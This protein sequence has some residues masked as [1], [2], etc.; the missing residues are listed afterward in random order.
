MKSFLPCGTNGVLV[1]S[2]AYVCS[3]LSFCNSVA[4]NGRLLLFCYIHW[5]RSLKTKSLRFCLDCPYFT[6]ATLLPVCLFYKRSIYYLF[7]L[8]VYLYFKPY[9]SIHLFFQNK[10]HIEKPSITHTLVS[11]TDG[12]C[13]D[14]MNADTT[15]LKTIL[16]RCF[17][18]YVK[19]YYMYTCAATLSLLLIIQPPLHTLYIYNKFKSSCASELCEN[20][21]KRS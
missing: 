5:K 15:N 8:Q 20:D 7:T 2:T 14:Q 13:T 6:I 19:R 21:T 12:S 11:K 10:K 16:T 18:L 1:Q 9:L 4:I 17:Q 3:L